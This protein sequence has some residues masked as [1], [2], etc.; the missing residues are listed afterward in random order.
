MNSILKYL[1]SD[2]GIKK[3]RFFQDDKVFGNK[4]IEVAFFDFYVCFIDDRGYYDCFICL[5]KNLDE[6]YGFDEICLLKELPVASHE[7]SMLKYIQKNLGLIEEN[8]DSINKLFEKTESGK[9]L[10]STKIKNAISIKEIML[11]ITKLY[12]ERKSTFQFFESQGQ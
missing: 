9:T 5:Q 2:A 6:A 3:Y 7:G 4:V 8:I 12:M 1:K 10:I 11:S